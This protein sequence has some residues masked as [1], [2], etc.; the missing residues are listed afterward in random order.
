MKKV[1]IFLFLMLCFSSQGKTWF[2]EASFTH[3]FEFAAA[4]GTYVDTLPCGSPVHLI[5]EKG[6][7]LYVDW[8]GKKGFLKK[9]ATA[10]NPPSC[11][12]EKYPK[13]YEALPIDSADLHYWGK[14]EEK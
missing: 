4:E 13:F 11:F 2:T 10:E 12:R 7:W 14:W 5:S 1:L 9:S 6:S 3:L 8:K